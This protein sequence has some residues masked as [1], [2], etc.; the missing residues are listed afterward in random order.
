[1][2]VRVG[3]PLIYVQARSVANIFDVIN[4]SVQLFSL[5][6]CQVSLVLERCKPRVA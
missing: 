1:M 5:V 4:W 3:G 2:R 6:A